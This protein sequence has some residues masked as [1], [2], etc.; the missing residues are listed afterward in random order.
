[1]IMPRSAWPLTRS[2]RLLFGFDNWGRENPEAGRT[3]HPLNKNRHFS[4]WR[5]GGTRVLS[6][7]LGGHGGEPLSNGKAKVFAFSLHI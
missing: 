2:T 6:L 7:L 5:N 4:R 1:M 3:H